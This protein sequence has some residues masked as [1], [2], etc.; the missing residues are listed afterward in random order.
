MDSQDAEG[1]ETPASAC[2]GYRAPRLDI[3]IKVEREDEPQFTDAPDVTE[4]VVPQG[5]PG[6]KSDLV[7]TERSKHMDVL[8]S[9]K[10]QTTCKN[11][12]GDWAAKALKEE[13]PGEDH[14]KE[15]EAPCVLA[16]KPY[17][18]PLTPGSQPGT[19][20]DAPTECTR[21]PGKQTV[22]AS[23]PR[24]PA[25]ELA[26]ACGDCGWRFG[27]V[28]SLGEH[29]ESHAAERTFIC[30]DCGKSFGRHATLVEH[31]RGHT[32]KSVFICTDCSKSFTH[33]AAL[34]VHQRTHVRQRPYRGAP[35][36]GSYGSHAELAAHQQAHAG[37]AVASE[38]GAEP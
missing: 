19:R 20:R 30:T 5:Y 3:S 25:G 1:E 22:R 8:D 29:E 36:D 32:A 18:S 26:L 23:Q 7:K 34:T 17:K 38:E 4:G 27:D 37:P 6:A 9:A 10:R 21:A 35:R 11:S 33:K 15:L 16:G 2:S 13:G 14:T 28:A 31:Q 24:R 12:T